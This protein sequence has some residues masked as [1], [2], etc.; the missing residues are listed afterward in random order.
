[1]EAEGSLSCTPDS[2]TEPY[3]EP[4]ESTQS[5]PIS[6]GSNLLLSTIYP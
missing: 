3:S 1:M 4:A 5:Q 2:D 6:L